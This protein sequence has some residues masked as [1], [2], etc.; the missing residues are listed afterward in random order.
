MQTAALLA[1]QD[2]LRLAEELRLAL[3]PFLS[4]WTMV[5]CSPGAFADLLKVHRPEAILIIVSRHSLLLE[6]EP[7]MDSLRPGSL[8]PQAITILPILAP[9][10]RMPSALKLEGDHHWFCRLNAIALS[11]GSMKTDAPRIARSIL[12]AG[13]VEDSTCSQD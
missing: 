3:R 6:D 12:D 7:L 4:G 8:S 1:D 13:T 11:E 2:E 5:V 9:H 10:A